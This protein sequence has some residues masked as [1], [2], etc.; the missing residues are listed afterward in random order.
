MSDTTSGSRVGTR[1]G[2][3]QLRRLLGRG[4]MGEV[5]EA[6]DT[7]K[8]RAVALKLMSEQFS[9]DDVFR[10]R[11]QREAHT[12]GRLQEPHI[13]P[14][15]DY[16]E[17]DGQ[18]FIDMRLVQGTDVST[19]LHREGPLPPARAVAVI[20]QVAEAL[21]AAHGAGVIHRDVKPENI[22]LAGE[23]FAYLVDFGIAA[24]FAD[25]RLTNTGTAIGSWNYMAPERF[26]NDEITY[27]ADIYALACVLF[28]C[29]TG[30]PPYPTDSLPALMAAHLVQPIPQPSRQ[31]PAIPTAFDHII[32]CGMAKNPT[33]RYPSAGDLARSAHDALTTTDQHRAVTLLEQSH[34]Y[35]PLPSGPIP[36]ARPPRSRRTPWLI[37]GAA[38][39]TVI[40]LITGL[41]IW[42]ATRHTTG[43]HP[44]SAKATTTTATPTTTTPLPIVAPAQLGSILPSAAQITDIMGASN[45]QQVAGPIKTQLEAGMWTLSMPDCDG[46]FT[47]VDARAYAGSGYSGVNSLIF[48]EPGEA[49]PEHAV[50]LGVVT[51]PTV[52]QANA[53]V[54]TSAAK[55][56]A[57]A[58]QTIT[59]TEADGQPTLWTFGDFS[60][61]V[62]KIAMPDMMQ[63]G[64][65][66]SCQH[67][68]S[69]V[70]NVVIDLFA[71]GYR[72]TDQASRIADVV[73]A[74][75][76]K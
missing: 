61:S 62:P 9:S 44:N 67:V 20:T 63:G 38:T 73:A 37:L 65:G 4:G 48:A 21:D 53:F 18:L 23:D 10:Q 2:P 15:H 29:L 35:A 34:Q 5:Y 75:V 69:A 41:G 49:H 66:Y 39:L 50:T 47:V 7:V 6:Y 11:M 17:I 33:D 70:S 52:E 60:G 74:N 51:F 71:C 31:N 12:A 55:W 76:A 36:W 24:A 72:I 56:K 16:G 46:A 22:L 58:G 45:M 64:G 27:R 26:G 59:D 43:A 57:C 30:T 3:Y 25:Q 1:F 32:A 40:A 8:D 13:L 28:E 68:L 19:V 42:K 14:I 54:T